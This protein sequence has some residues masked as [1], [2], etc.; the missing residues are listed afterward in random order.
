MVTKQTNGRQWRGSSLLM[1]WA[2]RYYTR[3]E[4]LRLDHHTLQDIGVDRMD[5][6]REGQKRF[7]R[8]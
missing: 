5:A 3:Q 8:A 4:L 1:T 7:W 6:I 2:E